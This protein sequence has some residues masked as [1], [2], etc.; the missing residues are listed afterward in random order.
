[1]AI[2]SAK[3]WLSKTSVNNI[4]HIN[5]KKFGTNQQLKTNM[6]K[7]GTKQTSKIIYHNIPHTPSKLGVVA[8]KTFSH[9]PDEAMS[10]GLAKA[11]GLE[12]MYSVAENISYFIENQTE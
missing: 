6:S 12:N 4:C 9:T 11:C 7:F 5:N 3:K 10:D 2:T 1:M 8:R